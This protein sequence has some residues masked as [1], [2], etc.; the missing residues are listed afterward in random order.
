[1]LYASNAVSVTA[2][3]LPAATLPGAVTAKRL[4]APGWTTRPDRVAVPS[5]AVVSDT[6][7]VCVPAVV[8][9]RLKM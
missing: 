1:L 2:K 5:A 8:S 9:V 6:V 7:S 3:V 4:A